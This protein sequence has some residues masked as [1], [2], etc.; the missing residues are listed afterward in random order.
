MF[1]S[2][3]TSI[4][5]VLFVMTSVSVGAEAV[6]AQRPPR[7]RA[8]RIGETQYRLS[9]PSGY[10]FLEGDAAADRRRGIEM[11]G[12]V[13]VHVIIIDC[14][15]VDRLREMVGGSLATATG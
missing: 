8:F 14:E 6:F 15:W 11:D 10:C 9:A 3:K 13:V 5:T 4:V 2:S 7:E 1:R 12:S